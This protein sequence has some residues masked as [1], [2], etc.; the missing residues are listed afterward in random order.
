MSSHKALQDTLDWLT[1]VHDKLW[2]DPESKKLYIRKAV[3]SR[4]DYE[5]LERKLQIEFPNR[6]DADTTEEIPEIKRKFIKSHQSDFKEVFDD[7]LQC[8]K[9][10]VYISWTRNDLRIGGSGS[11]PAGYGP[12]ARVDDLQ[13]GGDGIEHR[14]DGPQDQTELSKYQ[15]AS[16]IE[17][18]L[19]FTFFDYPLL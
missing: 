11:R 16:N 9:E 4:E 14:D 12:R 8:E 17:F 6:N 15:V 10:D 5:A 1:D 7:S 3:V 13:P 18:P 2:K 19:E